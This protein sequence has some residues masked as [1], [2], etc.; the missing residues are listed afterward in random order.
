MTSVRQFVKSDIIIDLVS[1]RATIVVM[2]NDMC[3]VFK[4]VEYSSKQSATR[5]RLVFEIS[6]VGHS[7]DDDRSGSVAEWWLGIRDEKNHHFWYHALQDTTD[8]YKH[9][10]TAEEVAFDKIS[11]FI[12]KCRICRKTRFFSIFDNDW[13]TI[14]PTCSCLA[15][16]SV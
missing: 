6:T 14:N 13:Q 4:L 9:V 11:Y 8:I 12:W 10:K 3:L 2:K 15:A 5:D 1:F 7:S 16:G